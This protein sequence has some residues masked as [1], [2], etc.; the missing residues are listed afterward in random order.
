MGRFTA[1][2]QTPAGA[3]SRRR[4]R[5]RSGASPARVGYENVKRLPEGRY[6]RLEIGRTFRG[7]SALAGSEE[8]DRLYTEDKRILDVRNRPE[9]TAGVIE[10]AHLVPLMELP[11]RCR[12]SAK[13][14]HVLRITARAAIV[15]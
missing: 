5:S 4:Q 9:W 2:R 3:G 15:P 10:G 6:Q 14:S 13:G 8:F 7:Y 11:T 12:T 1:R